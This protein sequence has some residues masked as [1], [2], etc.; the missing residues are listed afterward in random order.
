MGYCRQVNTSFLS[1]VFPVLLV[2]TISISSCT[3]VKKYQPGKPFVF[4]TNI[5]VRG[6]VKLSERQ[7]MEAKLFNQLDD[8]LKVKVV[9]FAGIKKT[10]ISPA[11]FDTVYVTR[12]IDYM[13]A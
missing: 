5:D 8:S 12:T 3:V 4:Q 10:L 2:V 6:N 11:V 9:S 13:S 7:D 1:Y